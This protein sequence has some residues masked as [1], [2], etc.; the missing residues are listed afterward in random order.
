MKNN[1][2]EKISKIQNSKYNYLIAW[3][4]N[5]KFQIKNNKLFFIQLIKKYYNINYKISFLY[6]I[7]SFFYYWSL[8]KINHK[9][10]I[11]CLKKND[12][13]CFYAIS[14]NV[15]ISSI[16]IDISIFII[17]FFDLEKYHFFNI[18]FIY[19]INL[20]VFLIF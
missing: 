8:A 3:K 9:I 17:L 12:I 20:V 2:Y 7:G 1:K 11:K 18:F 5:S 14:E 16:I 6:I 10:G 13:K 15:L 4:K 19:K